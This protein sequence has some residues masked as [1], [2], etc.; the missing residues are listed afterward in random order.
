LLDGFA[1]LEIS[2]FNRALE[3]F[4]RGYVLTVQGAGRT[5][6]YNLTGTFRALEA[7]REC[8][9]RNFNYAA[10]PAKP[11]PVPRTY[12]KTVTFQLATTI[13]TGLEIK[14]FRF[15]TQAELDELGQSDSVA[16]VSP[17]HGIMGWSLML[18]R[19]QGQS[20]LRVTDAGDTAFLAER[21]AGD[22]ATSA[23]ALQLGDGQTARELRVVCADEDGTTEH[24]VSKFFAG[25]F[26]VYNALTFFPQMQ[27]QTDGRSLSDLSQQATL[28]A[29]SFVTR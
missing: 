28:R 16:W 24:F 14:E 2:D 20:D 4:K 5:G 22:Y 21:C 19:E 27:G 17:E 8:A 11:A 29:A 7:A 23:R 9:I 1:G 3:V 13:L 12:D 15:L 10:V 18:P 6:Q 26:V 25:D